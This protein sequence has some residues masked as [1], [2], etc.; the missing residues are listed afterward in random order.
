MSMI[1][2]EGFDGKI[3]NAF[4]HSNNDELP[5]TH[6]SVIPKTTLDGGD[7]TFKILH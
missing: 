4:L 2:L 5:G 6:S 1:G 7:I 3:R